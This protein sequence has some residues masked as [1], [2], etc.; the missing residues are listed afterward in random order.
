MDEHEDAELVEAERGPGRPREPEVNQRILDAALELLGQQGYVRMSM[1]AV[2]AN[3]GV[4]KPT[5]YRRYP[6]KIQ[7]A[8]AAISAYCEQ[9]PPASTGETRADLIAQINHL[10]RALDRPRGM[11]MLGTMLAEEYETPELLARFR[12]HLVDP[13]RHAVRDILERAAM[14]G[15]FRPDADLAMAGTMLVGAYYAQ[16]LAR[17]TFA[18]DWTERLVDMVLA[19]MARAS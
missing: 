9:E 8:L 10:R 11:V 18:A 2:A 3:A 6:S 14:R 1:D 12:E 4:T 7:L 15:E 19:T 13:R 16:Y 5:I 17:T